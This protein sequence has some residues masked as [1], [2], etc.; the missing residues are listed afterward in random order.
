MK[1]KTVDK[2]TKNLF[3]VILSAFSFV[4]IIGA[5]L[6]LNSLFGNPVSKK[7]AENTAIEYIEENYSSDDYYIEEIWYDEKYEEYTVRVLS[8]TDKDIDLHLHI[9]PKGELTVIDIW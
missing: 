7:L 8:S 3:I 4:L 9:N 2:I 5:T 6:I 1:E